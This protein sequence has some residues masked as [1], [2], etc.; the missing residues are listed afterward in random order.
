MKVFNDIIRRLK[1]DAQRQRSSVMSDFKAFL[2]QSNCKWRELKQPEEKSTRFYFDYQGGHFVADIKDSDRGVDITFPG[3]A[4]MPIDELPLVRTLCNHYNASNTLIKFTYTTSEED[5]STHVHMSFFVNA[6]WPDELAESLTACFYYQ[7]Q[8]CDEYRGLKQT[9]TNNGTDDVERDHQQLTREQFMLAQQEMRHQPGPAAQWDFTVDKPTIA[10]LLERMLGLKSVKCDEVVFDNLTT[11]AGD[12]PTALDIVASRL[13]DGKPLTALVKFTLGDILATRHAT[14]LFAPVQQTNHTAQYWRV[15]ATLVPPSPSRTASISSEPQQPLAN[16]VLIAWS[17]IDTAKMRA[18]FDYMWQDALLKRRDGEPLNELQ[19]LIIDVTDANIGYNMY[20]GR[21]LMLD[22]CYY[23][24]LQHLENAFNAMRTVYLDLGKELRNAFV[25]ICYYIG[26]CYTE[27]H[28]YRD[29][30]Y[31]LDYVRAGG[32]VRH[33]T[34]LINCLANGKDFRLFSVTDDIAQA[35][36]QQYE[37]D[38]DIPEGLQ[39]FINFMRRRRAYAL[40][41]HHQLDEAE[42]AFTAMLDDPENSDYALS[43]LAYIKRLR[44]S[45]NQESGSENQSTS[46]ENH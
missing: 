30:F 38:E 20:W 27:L 21:K 24:A 4:D 8:F 46:A 19:Q 35:I 15:T 7:R 36:H 14:M 18:E 22:K 1:P 16:T 2:T 44:H 11:V 33:T 39:S 40:I 9:A 37:H 31:Y 10:Q 41:D 13:T 23:Q 5:N 17:G 12:D 45:E 6:I 32:N 34:E 29:A 28:L 43:E 25:E 3:I 26:F 42:K